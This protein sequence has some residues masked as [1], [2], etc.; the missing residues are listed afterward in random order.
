MKKRGVRALLM[1][2]QACV[3]YGAA[4]FS[5]DVDLAILADERNLAQLENALADLRAYSIYVPPLTRDYLLRGHACHFRAPLARSLEIRIDIMAVLH[6]CE[7]FPA[8]WKRRR[9]LRVS[10]IGLVNVMA[11]P[12]LVRAKKTQRD[13]DWPMA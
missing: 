2:G 9:R 1:G 5:R 11:L 7:P 10:R 13:K 4:E 8:M 3:L 6:G 12:D